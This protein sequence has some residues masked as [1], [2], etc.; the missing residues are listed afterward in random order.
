MENA[1]VAFI[2]NFKKKWTKLEIHFLL[3]VEQPQG[4]LKRQHTLN[5]KLYPQGDI[6]LI[7]FLR[8]SFESYE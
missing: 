6:F 1:Q 2:Y 7:H 5:N 4:F 3:R 8:H